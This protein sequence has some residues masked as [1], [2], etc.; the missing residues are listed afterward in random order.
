MV[1][2]LPV[3]FTVSTGLSLHSLPLCILVLCG[4]GEVK[5]RV[6]THVTA[7]TSRSLLILIPLN[8]ASALLWGVS[9]RT[10]FQRR[11]WRV[12]R[13]LGQGVDVATK[14]EAWH[15]YDGSGMKQQM[16]GGA[17]LCWQ[18]R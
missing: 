12:N 3:G 11:G 18:Q 6:Y 15:D 13:C 9:E 17:T 10:G 16:C 4:V 8:P 5:P 14:V 7:G 2:Q 1:T